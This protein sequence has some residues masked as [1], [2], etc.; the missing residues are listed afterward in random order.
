VIQSLIPNRTTSQIRTHAQKF[1]IK[2]ANV[3]PERTDLLE[4]LRSKPAKFFL[5]LS[6]KNESYEGSSENI[7]NATPVKRHKGDGKVITSKVHFQHDSEPKQIQGNEAIMKYKKEIGLT[8]V[9]NV[10]NNIRFIKRRML[11]PDKRLELINQSIS[12]QQALKD[13]NSD[14]L[15]LD[16]E[17][18]TELAERY[19]EAGNEPVVSDLWLHV[20]SNLESLLKIVKEL[21]ALHMQ[22]IKL[23]DLFSQQEATNYSTNINDGLCSTQIEELYYKSF[24]QEH[25]N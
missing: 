25:D 15:K 3:A 22:S 23:T 11:T 9:G 5:S 1:F 16:Q 10:E 17:H 6:G 14:V 4:F 12:I 19:K 7:E 21:T 20:H 24:V 2:L 13:L 18:S 8:Q